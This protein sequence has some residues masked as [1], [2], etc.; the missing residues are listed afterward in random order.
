MLTSIKRALKRRLVA[1][2][3][4]VVSDLVRRESSHQLFDISGER[5]RI[6][7]KNTARY[8]ERYLLHSEVLQDRPHYCQLDCF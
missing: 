2:V 7:L 1:L 6:A 5:Q 3:A 8:V 4:E